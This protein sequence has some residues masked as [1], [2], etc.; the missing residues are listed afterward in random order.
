MTRKTT[1]STLEL[2]QRLKLQGLQS[3]KSKASQAVNAKRQ[4]QRTHNPTVAQQRRQQN[5]QVEERGVVQQMASKAKR[6][7]PTGRTQGQSQWP[8][9]LLLGN[10]A[11]LFVCRRRFVRGRRCR[12]VERFTLDRRRRPS[13]A[14]AGVSGLCA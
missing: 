10:G 2:Q 1:V 7:R 4:I 12:F 14:G 8:N 5:L 3:P 13:R 6:T 9:Q 11:N